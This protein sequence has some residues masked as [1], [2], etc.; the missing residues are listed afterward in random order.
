MERRQV[1]QGPGQ[2]TEVVRHLQQKH[3]AFQ[4]QAGNQIESPGQ[5]IKRSVCRDVFHLLDL[6]VKAAIHRLRRI[7]GV[8]GHLDDRVGRVVGHLFFDGHIDLDLP[9]PAIDLLSGDKAVQ[10]RIPGAGPDVRGQQYMEDAKVLH[11]CPALFNNVSLNI[12]DLDVVLDEVLGGV[13]CLHNV[14]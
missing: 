4:N 12:G 14:R 1:C 13:P 2:Q 8:K 10:P 3:K 9:V 5:R 7:G 6:L 11:P